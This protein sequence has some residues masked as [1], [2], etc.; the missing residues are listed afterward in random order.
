MSPRVLIDRGFLHGRNRV[1]AKSLA[2]DVE[3]TGE[4]R[5]AEGPIAL[6]RNGDLMVATNDFSGL[7]SSD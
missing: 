2:D 3:P 6:P 1:V 7:V 5:I 4:R